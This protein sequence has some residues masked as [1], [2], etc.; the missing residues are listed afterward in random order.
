MSRRKLGNLLFF[1][2]LRIFCIRV[3]LPENKE[4]ENG[5]PDSR[6]RHGA[7]HCLPL[8]VNAT[9]RLF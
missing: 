8:A 9:L 6:N 1:Q 4:D 7:S 2:Q 3:Q 5:N